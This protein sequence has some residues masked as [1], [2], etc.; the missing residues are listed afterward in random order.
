MIALAW[1]SPDYPAG[2]RGVE[3]TPPL[4]YAQGLPSPADA[5]ALTIVG[6]RK[7]TTYGPEAARYRAGELARAG[8]TVVSGL[9]RGIDG[10]AH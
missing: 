10:A 8:V 9:A 6:N 5:Y 4:L 2:L 3:I 1:D 7:H